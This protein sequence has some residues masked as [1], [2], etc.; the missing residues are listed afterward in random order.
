MVWF[1]GFCELFV[2]W[3][4]REVAHPSGGRGG[5][6]RGGVLGLCLAF[7]RFGVYVTEIDLE[8]THALMVFSYFVPSPLSRQLAKAGCTRY[9]ER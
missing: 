7:W 9:T 4:G 5:G 2:P 1:A 6:G 8:E 3:A